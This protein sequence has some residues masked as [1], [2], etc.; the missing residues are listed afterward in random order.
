MRVP[1]VRRLRSFGVRRLTNVAA[2]L[3]GRPDLL[4][5]VSRLVAVMGRRRGHL[6]HPGEGSGRG[7]LFGHGPVFRDFNYDQDRD[8]AAAVLGFGLPTTLIPYEAAWEVALDASD[9][10]RLEQAGPASAW[11]AARARVA[12]LLE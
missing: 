9:L 3:R 2:P 10:A 6:F 4:D 8:A 7:I 1:V 11:V 5:H 12:R